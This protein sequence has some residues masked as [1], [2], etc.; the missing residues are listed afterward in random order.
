MP[1]L[2]APV[3]P[4]P[5]DLPPLP[6]G[7]GGSAPPVYSC[8]LT[9]WIDTSK[10][11][12]DNVRLECAITGGPPDG[13][14]TVEILHPSSGSV[15]HTINTTLTGGRFSATWVAK[16]QTADWR[17]DQIRFRV[18][19]AGLTCTSSNTFTFRARPTTG[20]V[21]QD[22]MRGCPG[23]ATQHRTVYDLDL[24]TN[25][26]LQTLKI[27]TLSDAGVPAATLTA[28]AAEVKTRTETVWNNGFNNK[29]F[30]RHTCQRGPA[31]DCTFDCCKAGFHLDVQFVASGQHRQVK[32]VPQ[33][34]PAAPTIGSWC[35]YDDSE[36]GYPAKAQ[37]STYAHEAGHML[38]QYDEYVTSCNDP[39]AA[40]TLYRQ[41][42][43]PPAA[44]NNLMSTSGNTTLLNRHYR[45]ILQFLNDNAGGDA[46]DIIPAGP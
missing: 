42:A 7:A 11:C 25:R 31:C 35:R 32:V 38:G 12:G 40:G 6:A 18:Q 1:N 22:Y 39:S 34:D 29:K 26:V 8:G 37:L 36:W 23:G 5:V 17:T 19:A 10:Y 4:A 21:N 3:V 41:P 44:E 33:P 15:I 24:E 9:R 16:A 46:Y 20:T 13:A 27:K 45:R 43:P 2:Q 28:F 30:H 14:A